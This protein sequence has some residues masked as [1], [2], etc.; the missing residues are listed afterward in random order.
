[1]FSKKKAALNPNTTDTLVGEGSIFEGKITSEASVRIEGQITG[2]IS[3]QGDVI[4]GEE[5]IVKSNIAARDV[6][7]AGAVHGNVNTKGKL[8]IMSTGKLYGNTNAAAFII[9]EGGLF[10]GMSKM[11]TEAAVAEETI[12]IVE[13]QKPAA[14]VEKTVLL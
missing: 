5:G 4:V 9:E 10:Q 1:M 11:D 6:V 3:C 12:E 8:T 7:I 2:D 14:Y 13:K